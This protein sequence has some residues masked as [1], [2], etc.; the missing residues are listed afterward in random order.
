MILVWENN[1]STKSLYF[2]KVVHYINPV[3][4]S[5]HFSCFWPIIL[6]M[7]LLRLCFCTHRVS[8]IVIID[9]RK[10]FTRLL[11]TFSRSTLVMKEIDAPLQIEFGSTYSHDS[12]SIVVKES[13]KARRSW[14]FLAHRHKHWGVYW[15]YTSCPPLLYLSKLHPL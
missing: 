2:S 8:L 4:A 12:L 14:P 7:S 6:L 5:R 1:K 13:K 15:Q 9:C 3:I 11:S 10:L